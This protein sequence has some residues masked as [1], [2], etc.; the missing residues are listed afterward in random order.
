MTPTPAVVHQLLDIAR[1]AIE[2]HLGGRKYQA[3]ILEAPWISSRPVFVTLRTPEGSLRGC[4]GHLTASRQSLADEIANDAVLA[5]TKD[6]R[7]P[8]VSLAEIS[9][10]RISISILGLPEPIPDSSY[11]DPRH[12][13]VV[14]TSG[15]KRGVLLPAINGIDTV[16]QQLR[17]ARRKASISDQAKVQLSRF[18]VIHVPPID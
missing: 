6:G 9:T 11:L 2:A 4:I 3:P 7:F 13:G 18:E 10:L 15:Q 17:I 5:A 1:S 16:E 12:F 14:I 8:A